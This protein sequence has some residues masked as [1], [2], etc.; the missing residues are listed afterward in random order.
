MKQCCG[1]HIPSLG[2]IQTIAGKN[3]TH[4]TLF[5]LQD[6]TSQY[7]YNNKIV[8]YQIVDKNKIKIKYPLLKFS[9]L[10]YILMAFFTQ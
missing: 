8:S 1:L 4:I 5:V 2:Q 3:A 9:N 7:Y 6:P 10:V